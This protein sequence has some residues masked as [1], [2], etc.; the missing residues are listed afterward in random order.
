[1]KSLLLLDEGDAMMLTCYTLFL[2][3]GGDI[4]IL[5]LSR[6]TNDD[7]CSNKQKYASINAKV[8]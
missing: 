6:M 4:R 8:H 3:D 1:M 7:G 2:S 5:V